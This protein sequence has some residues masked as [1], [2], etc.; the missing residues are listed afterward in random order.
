MSDEFN[1]HDRGEPINERTTEAISVEDEKQPSTVEDAVEQA[2]QKF[3]EPEDGQLKA[4]TD[5]SP[6]TDATPP[7]NSDES[8]PPGEQGEKQDPTP[9]TGSTSPPIH[10]S[11]NDKKVFSELP[12]AAQDFVMERLNGME[13]A[14]TRRSQEIAPMRDMLSQW[15]PYMDSVGIP[16]Q[17]DAINNLMGI[18][19]QL[20]TGDN[21]RKVAIIRDI[22]EQ[23][24]I[25]PPE[26]GAAL[27]S[28]SV[29]QYE[30]QMRQM[31]QRMAQMQQSRYTQDTGVMENQIAAFA[32]QKTEAGE[33]AHPHFDA[34]IDDIMAIAQT[35]VQSGRQPNPKDLYDQ[36]CYRNP[37]IRET[38][39]QALVDK[40]L[41]QRRAE[42]EKKKTAA[43]SVVGAGPNP[44]GSQ[45]SNS[46]RELVA[47]AYDK[48]GS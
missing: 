33:P 38:V 15:K 25:Q 17:I 14:H 1:P 7:K 22:M 23:Y 41:N 5:A 11:D 45:D 21:A 12:Q 37:Q 40:T 32:G 48:F 27:E 31:Q 28:P 3:S 19:Y 26:E 2:Y 6:G 39:T 20:R 30:N 18:E 47:T 34:V 36:A 35:E 13:A 9:Q 8:P 4:E 43:S 10:W 29:Y 46:I 44:S 24:G 42:M 16:D